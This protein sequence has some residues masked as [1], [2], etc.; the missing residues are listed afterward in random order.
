MMRTL[1][2]SVRLG[3]IK[4]EKSE[5]DL[6]SLVSFFRRDWICDELPANTGVNSTITY[7]AFA[8]VCAAIHAQ[9]A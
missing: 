8:D 9:S 7:C 4:T 6:A 2:M 1:W 3:I 5:T